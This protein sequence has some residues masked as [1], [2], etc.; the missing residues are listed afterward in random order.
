[1]Y[2]TVPWYRQQYPEHEGRHGIYRQKCGRFQSQ[3]I[4]GF[5]DLYRQWHDQN[6]PHQQYGVI[7]PDR[8]QYPLHV[9]QRGG[10]GYFKK[11]TEFPRCDRVRSHEWG[12]N[13]Q[14]LWSRWSCGTGTSR[15]LWY[16]LCTGEFWDGIQRSIGGCTE[17]HHFRGTHQWF[18]AENLPYQ[19]CG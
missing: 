18:P 7:F 11:W 8:R 5:P 9:L 2:R 6:D 19:I 10:N 15:R 3:W 16:D 4:C 13:L 12:C 17:R 1:M 14:L